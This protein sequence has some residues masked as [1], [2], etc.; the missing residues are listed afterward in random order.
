MRTIIFIGAI[1]IFIS[2]K[3]ERNINQPSLA[4]KIKSIEVNDSI[5]Q[6][7]YSY[8]FYYN[9][10]NN[11]LS[12]IKKDG[13]T[14][15]EI[16]HLNDSVLIITRTNDTLGLENY[17]IRCDL[18]KNVQ[19]V[20]YKLD[21]VNEM[22]IYSFVYENNSISSA[23][24]I[25]IYMINFNI[26][27]YTFTVANN[28]CNS[29]TT[30]YYNQN[31]VQ[32]TENYDITYN[33]YLYNINIP[34]QSILK[35]PDLYIFTPRGVL[36]LPYIAQLCGLNVGFTNKNLIKEKRD[37]RYEYAFNT[38]NEAVE[39]KEYGTYSNALYRTYKLSY[40]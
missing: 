27:N 8:E 38:M 4:G 7:Q 21:S 30:T 11:A 26:H 6:T 9:G 15:I 1:L 31:F 40:Y 2:C 5:Q 39:I 32:V 22:D 17:V 10:P 18:N 14:Y 20:K 16:N 25:G 12:D 28:N 36:S 33:D 3:K 34:F 19:S 13:Q 23:Y 35:Y 29:F 24:E 37:W